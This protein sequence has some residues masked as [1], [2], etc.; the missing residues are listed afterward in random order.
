MYLPP[1]FVVIDC[2]T[3]GL[4]PNEHS[5]IS[6]AAVTADGSTFYRECRPDAGATLCPEALAVNGYDPA[7]WDHSLSSADAVEQ[8]LDWL[9]ERHQGR[10]IV[11]GKNPQFDYDFL[12]ATL[13]W[14]GRKRELKDTLCRYLVDLNDLVYGT[15]IA[16]G[17]DLAEVGRVGCYEALGL[18]Q[19]VGLHHALGGAQCAMD[20]FRA[21]DWAGATVPA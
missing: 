15:A 20:C 5:L 1:H 19:E 11:G 18:P 14:H 10:W 6:V 4:D 7:R 9:A 8:L 16:R 17:V 12:R 21:L 13:R 3:T 2:E